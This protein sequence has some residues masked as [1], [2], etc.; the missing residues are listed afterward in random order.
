MLQ[1]E[2]KQKHQQINALPKSSPLSYEISRFYRKLEKDIK[3]FDK[4]ILDVQLNYLL[5]DDKGNFVISKSAIEEIERMNGLGVTVY[6]TLFAYILEDES[7]DEEYKKAIHDIETKEV[8][9]F[10][11]SADVRAKIVSTS[12]GTYP[13]IEIIS[14]YFTYD[15]INLLEDLKII[16]NLD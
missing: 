9:E 11:R 10:E 2:L 5:V 3:V 12:K 8:A 4:E 13:L 15:E 16:T 14:D 6:P 7:M 1:G